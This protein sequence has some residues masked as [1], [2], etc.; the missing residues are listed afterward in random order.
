MIAGFI[1]TLQAAGIA[2]VLS[3]PLLLLLLIHEG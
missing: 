2:C 1:S 3:Q